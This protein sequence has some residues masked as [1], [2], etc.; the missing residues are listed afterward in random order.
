MQFVVIGQQ[1]ATIL[2]SASGRRRLDDP[3]DY[4]RREIV[5]ALERGILVVPVLV[6]GASVPKRDHLPDDLKP[7][8]DNEAYEITDKRWDYDVGVLIKELAKVVG[9]APS[10]V[11]P[12]A[13]EEG[14]AVLE[15]A[16][17]VRDES[18]R[19][20]RR[21]TRPVACQ[22]PM[23]HSFPANAHWEGT[24]SVHNGSECRPRDRHPERL[25][26]CVAR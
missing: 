17:S 23:Q 8:V 4:V 1:W 10:P 25:G 16:P 2:D 13:S 11:S 15:L 6:H 14:G 9:D 12:A 18:T 24:T 7:L 26:F 22:R 19:G 3:K 20:G 21:P 5:R